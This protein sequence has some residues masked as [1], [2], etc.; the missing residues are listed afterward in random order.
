MNADNQ[1]AVYTNA[2][3]K[4]NQEKK[5]LIKEIEKK[6][7]EIDILKERITA[8]NKEN[9]R[10]K[11]EMKEKESEISS[12]RK[13]VSESEQKMA[14]YES[15]EKSIYKKIEKD[16]ITLLQPIQYM[17]GYENAIKKSH[18]FSD[19]EISYSYNYMITSALE[20]SAYS[21]DYLKLLGVLKKSVECYTADK[22]IFM[23]I[24]FPLYYD[25]LCLIKSFSEKK[26][27]INACVFDIKEALTKY[28]VDVIF[29]EDASDYNKKIYFNKGN[30]NTI[31]IPILT[32]DGKYENV[33]S[34]TGIYREY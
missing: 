13:K 16:F 11:E 14:E 2:M 22:N 8:L 28:N 10:L 5:L 23:R 26:V 29:Y 24:M 12:L 3:I 31:P 34:E 6:E 7:T 17:L 30:E 25:L 20:K 21:N 15:T 33:F 1:K 32:I 18:T 27:D 19:G 4:A 9:E